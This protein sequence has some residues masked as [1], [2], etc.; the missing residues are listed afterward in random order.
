METT[1]I[2][3]PEEKVVVEKE[4]LPLIAQAQALTVKSADD[5]GMVVRFVDRI[6]A[7]KTQI[8]ERFHPTR[9]RE[10]AHKH[11]QAL[12][13]T[14]NAFYAP[15]DR[16]IE[17]AK[18]NIRKFD[19]EEALKVQRQAEEAEAKRRQEEREARE[20]LE[21]KAKKAEEK[22]Q[23]EKA[24]VFREQAET[25][26][27]P[28]TFTPPPAATKKLVWKAR[29]TNMVLLCSAIVRGDVPFNVLEVN[30]AALNAWAK[31]HDGKTKIEGLMFS[32][33]VD[34]R[35]R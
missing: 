4:V 10:A 28:P 33:D 22:G 9:N 31:G 19:R 25:V 11:W 23:T 1:A 17:I 20:R 12:K 32:Q 2:L 30:Q 6:K 7:L 13:E 15:M 35:I 14:E 27:V 8:E 26:I 29:V 16:A 24:E 34:S 18:D 21:A 5:R 3:E